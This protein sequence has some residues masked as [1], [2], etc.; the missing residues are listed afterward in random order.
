MRPVEAGM[1]ANAARA[2]ARRKPVSSALPPV[3]TEL[4]PSLLG[5]VNAVC[6]VAAP[7]FED[8]AGAGIELAAPPPPQAVSASEAA[9]SI[10]N[11]VAIDLF[12]VFFP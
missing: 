5:Q 8:G 6:V 2:G 9:A 4:V 7:P 11:V 3:A 10:P 1:V 12:N